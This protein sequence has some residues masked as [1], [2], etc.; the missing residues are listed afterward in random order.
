MCIRDSFPIALFSDEGMRKGTKST[1]YG[2][3][4]PVQNEIVFGSKKCTVVDGGY[5]LHKVVWSSTSVVN[6]E[7]VCK[8][9]VEYVQSHFGSNAVVVFD[10]YPDESTRL[11]T[12]S[13]ERS[14]RAL[15][16]SSAKI[17]FN[18]TTKVT[19]AQDKFLSND[20][21][22]NRLIA[23]LKDEMA[24]V[25]IDVVQ[26]TEDAD[27]LIINTAK[28]KA[29]EFDSVTII[30]EDID[31]LV[32]LT[33]LASSHDNIYFKK[34][35]RGNAPCVFYSSNSFKYDPQA[36]LF[37]HVFSGCDTTSAP[38]GHGKAKFCSAL[39]KQ[40][41][42]IEVVSAFRKSEATP[43]QI[44]KAGEKFFV[45][46]YGGD[47][48]A[49]TLDDLRCQLFEKS[50]TKSKFHLARLP[51]TQD[52]AWYHA[53]RTYQV[54]TW[55]GREKNPLDWGWTTGRRGM[56]PIK[57]QKTLHQIRCCRLFF[58]NVKKGV[59]SPAAAERLVCIALLLVRIP[60][61]I[62]PKCS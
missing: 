4:T 22:K 3:F 8:N 50:V 62:M 17:L 20:S 27:V 52:A 58:A 37:L 39:Q 2:S 57:Q 13:W 61:E 10:G 9:Y 31:L 59:L 29:S 28:S 12:K 48:N 40:P 16:H 23:L 30:G 34:S 56:T 19:I 43:D 21:N 54:Q 60:V 1:L 11:S 49:Q 32:L 51:P 15:L 18:K 35:G 55:M 47:M 14:R 7:S 25:G 45:A 46:L 24:E 36:I 5:L 33:A 41:N 38:F 6:F 26:A 44:G 53:L 42:L